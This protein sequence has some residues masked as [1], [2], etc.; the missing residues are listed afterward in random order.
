M[1]FWLSHLYLL[2]PPNCLQLD[3]FAVEIIQR[4]RPSCV[5]LDRFTFLTKLQ[6]SVF[7]HQENRILKANFRDFDNCI[8]SP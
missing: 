1:S 3:G 8:K 7:L 5:S 4:A 2:R 6:D